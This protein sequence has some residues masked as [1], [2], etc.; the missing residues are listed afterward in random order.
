MVSK[1]YHLKRPIEKI[2]YGLS[3]I[4]YGYNARKY[5]DFIVKGEENLPEESAI[6]VPNHCIC[7]DGGLITTNIKKQIHYFVQYENVYD[8][9]F[10]I[11]WWLTGQIPVKVDTVFNRVASKRSKD[12][13]GR[14]EDYIGIFSE[15]PTKDLIDEGGKPIEIKDRIHHPS[16]SSLAAKNNKKTIIKTTSPSFFTR[17]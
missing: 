11:F 13:L 14:T 16:A 12:Y 7:F 1:G 6:I 9:K 15:G 2:F 17:I 10:K 4:I 5:L 3:K 8:S